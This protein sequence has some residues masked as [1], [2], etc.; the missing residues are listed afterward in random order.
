MSLE[1][2]VEWGSPLSLQSDLPLDLPLNLPSEPQLFSHLPC[3]SARLQACVVIPARDEASGIVRT[4]QALAAQRDLDGSQLDNSR[5]EILLLCNNCRDETAQIARD[6]AKNHPQVALFVIEAHFSPEN[7]NVGHARRLLMDAACARLGQSA[8]HN[9]KN[10]EIPR[11]ICSTDADTR[12]FP[13]WIA[14][15]LAEIAAGAEAVGGRILIE[16][17]ADS[18]RN[19]T[20]NVTRDAAMRRAYLLDTAY[21]LYAAR[22][23]TLLDPQSAD[24]WPRHFQF[25][26]A[27]IAVTPRAY[28]LVGG[29]PRVSQL[30]DMQFEAALRCHDVA[31]RHSP[32]VRVSTSARLGG[33]VAIGL[34]TQLR[35]WID[36]DSQNLVWCVPSGYE[37]GEKLRARR[38][39]RTLHS[40]FYNQVSDFPKSETDDL[41][42]ALRLNP[43]WLA[44]RMQK[45]ACF[46]ALWHDVER[47]L[48]ANSLFR[49]QWPP[50]AVEVAIT[51][52]RAMLEGSEEK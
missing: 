24:P 38:A 28:E 10:A 42:G 45:T 33:R 51:Q 22:L 48:N 25:F 31:L 13:T 30:E 15:N 5:F 35:E 46:G 14:A 40:N 3:P 50:V 11:A 26:G 20:P 1:N 39:L 16:K 12:V 32:H 19:V 47:A 7:Q 29:L 21:R 44:V 49:A 36:L 17:T 43:R 6:F 4:L 34:S 18:P 8:R 9:P 27:S 52:L 2:R 41:A 37:L 23:E